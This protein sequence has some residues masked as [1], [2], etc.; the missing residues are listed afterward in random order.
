MPFRKKGEKMMEIS[1][2]KEDWRLI[3][4]D[5]EKILIPSKAATGA[6]TKEELEKIGMT[7]ICSGES[8]LEINSGIVR[9]KPL[10]IDKRTKIISDTIS[11]TQPFEFAESA[12][13]ELLSFGYVLGSY[14]LIPEIMQI[15]AGR[16]IIYDNYKDKPE[17]SDIY[18]NLPEISL[19]SQSEHEKAFIETLHE[20][21]EESI[22]ISRNKRIFVPLSGGYDSRLLVCMLKE[23][24]VKNV[25]C[26]SYGLPGAGSKET[27]ISQEVSRRLGYP[28]HYIPYNIDKLRNSLK[29]ERFLKYLLFAHNFSSLPHIQ[30]FIALE[31]IE[32]LF[33]NEDFILAPGHS[34]D[35]SAGSH[36]TALVE[37]AQKT[38][39]IWDLYDAIIAKHFVLRKLPVPKVIKTNLMN[40]LNELKNHIN[41]PYRVFEV[42]DWYERQAKFIV[43]SVRL[44]EFFG[45]YWWLPFWDK[46]FID[47]WLSIPIEYKLGKRLYNSFVQKIF[48]KYDVNFDLSTKASSAYKKNM[49]I[50]L[51]KL[52]GKGFGRKLREFY[53]RKI[54]KN[55]W[56]IEEVAK[57]ILM[58]FLQTFP[59]EGKVVSDFVTKNFRG[60][61]YDPNAYFSEIL[62]VILL[63]N[64][65]N[66]V[67]G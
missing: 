8:K 24:N 27:D 60:R 3:S 42:W 39:C 29:S 45:H 55:P 41:E 53:M 11:I 67:K 19:S 59:D 10:F 63:N 18:K 12:I 58:H 13:L 28:W 66:E 36:L 37:N 6:T 47:F 2:N 26:F 33:P 65:R 20:V 50:L 54:Y 25:V 62:L 51:T 22:I 48:D 31:E 35:F 44:Y 4:E 14:T 56:G 7:F 46:R 1:I 17:T 16:K 40:D 57:D 64:F 15:I 43:N 52:L 49:E 23:F 30:E 38:R 9:Q 61:S 32:K 34:A 5:N 21:F